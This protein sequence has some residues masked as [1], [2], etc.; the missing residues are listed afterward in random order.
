MR[1]GDARGNYKA[2]I[3]SDS[4]K[5]L[6]ATTLGL[7][8]PGVGTGRVGLPISQHQLGFVPAVPGIQVRNGG[9][10][11]SGFP[12]RSFTMTNMYSF[13]QKRLKGLSI[14][15]SGRADFGLLRY[16]YNDAAKGNLRTP[17]YWRDGYLLSAIIGYERP[18][19]RKIKWRTQINVNNALDWREV[20]RAP[21]VA[22][23]IVDN[24]LLRNDPM[25]WVWT[26]TL[27]F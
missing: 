24:A 26:N 25:T 3:A 17:Y 1:A 10:K 27:R 4:G 5:I 6:N 16:Y 18:I 23:G 20:E 14:G 9:E 19:T 21:N 7:T 11:T 2:E 22:T 13:S 12:R 8:I 15:F